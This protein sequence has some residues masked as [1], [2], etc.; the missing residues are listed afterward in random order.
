MIVPAKLLSSTSTQ[1]ACPK[2]TAVA[3]KIPEEPTTEEPIG[4]EPAGITPESKRENLNILLESDD[5]LTEEEVIDLSK[6]RNSL[7]EMGVALDKLLNS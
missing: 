2:Q 3:T 5:F 6:G 1:Q 7:G 4:G